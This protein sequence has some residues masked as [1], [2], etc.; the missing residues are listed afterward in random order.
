MTMF[1]SIV[2]IVSIKMTIISR[3]SYYFIPFVLLIL[4]ECLSISKNKY[5]KQFILVLIYGIM[6]AK[7]FY[8]FFNLADTLF[9]VMP[10][11]FF[12]E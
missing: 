11:K 7:Y 10:Y 9:G 5:N 6:M 4:P 8:I 3:L 1:Y 2:S 12:W